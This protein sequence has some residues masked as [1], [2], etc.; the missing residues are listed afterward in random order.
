MLLRKTS[1]QTLFR[2]AMACLALF[3][4]LGVPSLKAQLSEDL[5][6]SLRGALL[7]ANIALVFLA[8]RLQRQ[9]RGGAP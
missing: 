4:I 1:P 2:L 5:L 6:D 7:G 8:F 9:Q 3:G